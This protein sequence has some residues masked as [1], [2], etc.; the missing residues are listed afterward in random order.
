MATVSSFTKEVLNQQEAQAAGRGE[1]CGG[2]GGLLAPGGLA[3]AGEPDKKIHLPREWVYDA[4]ADQ[5]CA[6][7]QQRRVAPGQRG[8]GTGDQTDHGGRETPR[9][10]QPLAWRAR[11]LT[12]FPGVA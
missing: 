1:G 10:A 2:C 6:I 8:R 11:R 3:G 7:F 12:V 4:K 5:P 9:T